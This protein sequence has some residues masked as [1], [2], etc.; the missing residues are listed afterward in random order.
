LPKAAR[1][2]A[3]WWGATN[4]GRYHFAH[5]LHWWR[6]GY[7]ADRPD[8]IAETV[9]FRRIA[10]QNASAAVRSGAKGE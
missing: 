9:T 8:F 10:A 7:A 4:Q 5:T 3:G 6:A 1:L 2:D